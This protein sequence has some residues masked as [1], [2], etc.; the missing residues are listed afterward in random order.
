MNILLKIK[1]QYIY[2][3][4]FTE[5]QFVTLVRKSQF[6]KLRSIEEQ[7][8]IIFVQDTT[9]RKYGIWGFKNKK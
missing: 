3:F 2:L 5:D 9:T 1:A 7:D 6:L 4:I 8:K